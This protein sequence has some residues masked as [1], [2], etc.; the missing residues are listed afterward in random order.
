MKRPFPSQAPF[1]L[2]DP[3]IH[4]VYYGSRML[5][6]RLHAKFL[7]LVL[8]GLSIF[9]GVLSYAL[10]QRESNILAQKADEE[11]HVLAF[12]VLSDLKQSMLKGE[13]RSTLELMDSIRGTYGLIRLQVVRSDG[14][15]AFGITGGRLVMPQID[16][17]IET[18][19]EVSFQENVLGYS[20]ITRAPGAELKLQPI[21]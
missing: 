12:T 1:F 9:L 3:A 14:S 15:P 17:V 10:V 19:G 13:P 11:Q 8:G 16:R 2:V 7:V 20:V 5:Q 21:S 6:I 18:G 4:L